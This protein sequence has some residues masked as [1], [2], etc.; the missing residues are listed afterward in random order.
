MLD[1]AVVS[2]GGVGTSDFMKKLLS[3]GIKTNDKSD[4]DGLKHTPNPSKFDDKC[5]KF[6]YMFDCPILATKSHFRRGWY[7]DQVDKVS[8]G[9]NSVSKQYTWDDFVRDDKDWCMMEDHWDNWVNSGK[10]ILFL[11]LSTAY[12]HNDT[13]SEFIGLPQTLPFFRKQER[14]CRLLDT[15]T[16]TTFDKLIEKQK[17]FGEFKFIS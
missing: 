7:W 8:E 11:K 6:I 9:K 15:D 16:V 4:L 2:Y 3:I 14:N 10:N 17:S 13:V 12:M 1:L 5:S